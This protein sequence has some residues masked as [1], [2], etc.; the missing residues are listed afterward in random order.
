MWLLR[1]KFERDT[2]NIASYNICKNCVYKWKIKYWFV[3]T[4]IR[5]IY[6]ISV[7]IWTERI[8]TSFL[9]RYIK[10]E[11]S[12]YISHYSNKIIFK[13][14][15]IHLHIYYHYSYQLQ[16]V[17]SG[18][19]INAYVYSY[20]FSKLWTQKFYIRFNQCY[21]LPA[22]LVTQGSNLFSQ[23]ACRLFWFIDTLLHQFHQTTRWQ[24]L[25]DKI[26]SCW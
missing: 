23:P 26:F 5:I 7:N 6:K 17:M 14:N 2:V 10:W 11:N 15:S 12:V 22:R 16:Y 24:T 3:C 1:R 8:H 19:Y 18:F 13:Y 9:F 20:I 4:I 25:F 21:N